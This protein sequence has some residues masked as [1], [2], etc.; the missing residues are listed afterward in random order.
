[1]LLLV[2]GMKNMPL[3]QLLTWAVFSCSWGKN[4][5][6]LKFQALSTKMESI[7]CYQPF[8]LQSEAGKMNQ[9]NQ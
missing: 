5:R 2:F 6:L 7:I 1:M 8:R 3:S 9:K 4:F